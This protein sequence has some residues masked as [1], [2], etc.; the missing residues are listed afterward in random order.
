MFTIKPV[1]FDD[2]VSPLSQDKLLILLEVLNPSQCESLEKSLSIATYLN[3]KID[4]LPNEYENFL[5]LGFILIERNITESSRI[6][7]EAV[8][9]FFRQK[10]LLEAVKASLFIDTVFIAHSQDGHTSMMDILKDIRPH[11]GT[12]VMYN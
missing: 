12:T 1:S 7:A 11:S 8:L 10:S 3:I 5:S 9:D 4:Q 2:L 6:W